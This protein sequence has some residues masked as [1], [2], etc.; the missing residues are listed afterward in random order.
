MAILRP[1]TLTLL[2][3]SGMV[4]QAQAARIID[5]TNHKAVNQVH[6]HKVDNMAA[7]DRL[8]QAIPDNTASVV[9]LRKLDKDG[10]Q[11]SANVAINDRFQV[12][13]QPNNYSQIYTCVGSNQIS[14]EITGHKNNDL[15]KNAHL[16]QLSANTTY[17]FEIDVDT[18]GN[19]TVSPISQNTAMA[20][21]DNMAYQTHQITRVVPNCPVIEPP[22][23]KPVAVAPAPAPAPIQYESIELKVLFDNDKS[24]VKPNYYPEV[25]R[26]ADF[27]ARHPEV[28]ATIEGHTDSNASD[29][30]N[31]KL[32]QRRV[33]AV[34]QILID[35]FD[36][37]SS[38]LNAI[39]YGESRPIATNATAEGRQQNR[40]VVAVFQAN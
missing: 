33:D 17:F 34:K 25:K 7:K 40:R 29:S 26:V 36:I 5:E 12:S 14:A 16:Y 31:L 4:S 32:S 28:S 23:P 6:W 21:L 30:Y 35:K 24:L 38:R 39:G 19:T 13:L 20:A 15:L 18:Q 22:A 3:A 37:E 8:N 1:V 2:L 27:M 9:F 11:T 10:L